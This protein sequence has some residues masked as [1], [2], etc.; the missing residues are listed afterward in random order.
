MGSGTR[1]GYDRR[2]ARAFGG[3]GLPARWAPLGEESSSRP[4]VEVVDDPPA[5]QVPACLLGQT[6]LYL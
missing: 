6:V 2:N 4:G 5:P 3:V 1:H